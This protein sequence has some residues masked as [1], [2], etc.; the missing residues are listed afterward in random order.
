MKNPALKKRATTTTRLAGE[1][2]PTDGCDD[3]AAAQD[4]NV[5]AMP[6]TLAFFGM[7][8]WIATGNF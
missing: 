8:S 3:T 7:D 4:S 1:G 5:P 6:C 2:D